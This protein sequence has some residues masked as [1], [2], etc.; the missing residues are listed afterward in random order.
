MSY[1][2]DPDYLV[3]VL[4]GVPSAVELVERL[5]TN[6]VGVSIVSYGE[7][8]EGAFSDLDPAPRLARMRDYLAGFALFSLTDHGRLCQTPNVPP[9]QRDADSRHGSPHRRHG[10]TP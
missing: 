10:I 4:A 3:D 6:G 5:A 9:A 1:L 7:I 2:V 8:Y